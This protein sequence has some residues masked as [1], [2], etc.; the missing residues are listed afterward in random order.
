MKRVAALAVMATLPF[1]ISCGPPRWET[2]R[3]DQF[4][5]N[6]SRVK[7]GEVIK[8]IALVPGG[9]VVGDAIGVELAKR[10][11]VII[12]TA[13]TVS[14]VTGVDFKAI[15]EHYIPARRNPGEIRNLGDQLGVQGVDAFLVVRAN[16]FSP[17]QYLGHTYWQSAD[18]S[19]FSA[20]GFEESNYAGGAIYRHSWANIHD[21]PKSPA[22]A[23]AEI[24]K[25]LAFGPGAI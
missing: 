2:A 18:I 24:V 19:I 22:E 11:F 13:T 9:G 23:A 12:P 15:A 7:S 1:L 4:P 10:G 6:W 17:R 25:N 3:Y 20:R 21:R 5:F 8:V 16:D 14:M